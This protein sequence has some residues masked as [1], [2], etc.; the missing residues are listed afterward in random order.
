MVND[1]LFSSDKNFWE[2]PQKLFDELDAEFHFTLD[3]AA[4]DEN[5]KCARYFTQSDDGLRQNWEGETVFCN[6][7]YG[8][9]ETGLWTEKCYR[10]GQ[11]PGTTVVL[12]I[13]ART[14]R[15]SFHDYILGKAE[16]RFLR[17]RLKFELDGK[18]IGTAPFPSMIAIWRGG[19]T[20]YIGEPFSWKPAAFQGSAGILSVTTKETTAHGRV[21]YINKAPPLLYGGGGSQREEAQRE[22]Q[23]LGGKKWTLLSL[24]SS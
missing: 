4:S 12:L 18:P 24:L 14:D 7:P 2:T 16:I 23:I 9:K 21:V 1:A 11:K 3:V 5:H 15:A 19:M 10:E 13:P 20:M 8:S 22:L 17:G 6:P